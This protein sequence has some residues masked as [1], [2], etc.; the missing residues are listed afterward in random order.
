MFD[1]LISLIGNENLEKINNV[2]VCLIGVGGVGG[3]TL[4]ALVRSGI[5]NITIYD[6][7]IIDKSN[8]NRQLITDSTNIGEE[9]I[10][11]AIKRCKLINA[12][13]NIKGFSY[14]ITPDNV[15]ELK[16]YDYVIDACDDINAKVAIIKYCI[17]NNIK[18]VCALGTGKRL[19]PMGVKICTLDKTN[20]DA[21][22][23]SLRQ[24]LRKENISLKIPVV[25][26]SDL[27]I[28]NDK[29]IASSIFSPATAGLYLA[30]YVIDDIIKEK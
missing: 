14:N 3:F 29:V 1:R 17:N 19:S 4:E 5:N 16:E 26:N 24:R 6:G 27:P 13:I 8:L 9:K 25:Y 21:L 28:N 15:L 10:D 11:V 22:A 18:I 30:Y 20:N 23:R 12:D 2:R 7:D